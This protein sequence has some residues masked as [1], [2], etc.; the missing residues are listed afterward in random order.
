MQLGHAGR[1]GGGDDNFEVRQARFQ[2]ANELRAD[3]DFADADGVYPQDLAIG[4]R[5]LEFGVVL[6]ETLGETL[7]PM[8]AAPHSH[9]VIWRG[10]REKDREQD[11]V[12]GTHSAL[13]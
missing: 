13:H 1:G 4:D 11:V 3:I 5:L 12:K 8:A 10:Q 7:S 6:A 2:G 9:K